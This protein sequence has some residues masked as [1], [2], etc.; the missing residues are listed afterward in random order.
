MQIST[1]LTVIVH[2]IHY[3]T[4]VTKGLWQRNRAVLHFHVGLAVIETPVAGVAMV[5][6][7]RDI[8]HIQKCQRQR[9]PRGLPYSLHAEFL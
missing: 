1:L 7:S 9:T 2:N 6:K 5:T 4:S 3:E 8:K